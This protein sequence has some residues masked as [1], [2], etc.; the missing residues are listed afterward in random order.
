LVT[1]ARECCSEEAAKKLCDVVMASTATGGSSY[2][3]LCL[4]YE[5]YGKEPSKIK[6]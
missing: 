3:G 6:Q 2:L 4:F 1:W 5:R